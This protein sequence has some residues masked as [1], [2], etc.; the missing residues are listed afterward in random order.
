MGVVFVCVEKGIEGNFASNLLYMRVCVCMYVCM[1]IYIYIYIYIIYIY[2]Y[3][4]VHL[5]VCV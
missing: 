1:Y 4:R 3:T 5:F 2:I